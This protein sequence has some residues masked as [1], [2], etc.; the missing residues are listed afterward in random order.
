MTAGFLDAFLCRAARQPEAVAFVLHGDAAA[1]ALTNAAL[2]DGAL[3]WAA[4]LRAR[5]ARAGD[6]I[7]LSL[8][9]GRPLLEAFLGTLVAGCVPS[10]MPVPTPQAGAAAVLVE[11]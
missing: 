3:R 5:G 2:R 7:L 9:M 8:P 4:L 1:P 11:P 10:M 6:V